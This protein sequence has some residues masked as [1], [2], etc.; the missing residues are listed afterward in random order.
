MSAML[1]KWSCAAFFVCVALFL[2]A[3][4]TV[5]ADDELER[6]KLSVLLLVDSAVKAIEGQPV[7]AQ[8]IYRAITGDKA[9][10]QERRNSYESSRLNAEETLIKDLKKKLNPIFNASGLL[11][12]D[13]SWCRK[14]EKQALLKAGPYIEENL[15]RNFGESFERARSNAVREQQESLAKVARPQ[16]RQDYEKIEKRSPGLRDDLLR[17]STQTYSEPIFSENLDYLGGKIDE[18]IREARQQYNRQRTIVRDSQGGGK[19]AITLHSIQTA[20]LKELENYR[21]S[22]QHPYDIFPSV[23]KSILPRAKEIALKK[24]EI[25]AESVDI[26]IPDKK[27]RD[28]IQKNIP[29]HRI[30]SE[31]RQLVMRTFLPEIQKKTME[32][33]TK[34]LPMAEKKGLQQFLKAQP[35]YSI[36]VEKVTENS[37]MR[38]SAVRGA[39]GEEQFAHTFPDLAVGSWKLGKDAVQ[40]RYNRDKR[41]DNQRI[42]AALLSNKSLLEETETMVAE[43]VKRLA[44]KGDLALKQ[45]MLLVDGYR[46]KTEKE[47][48]ILFQQ[49]SDD[50]LG[51]NAAI[52]RL[53][54]IASKEIGQTWSDMA[55]SKVY[56][57][58][59]DPVEDQ[60]RKEVKDLL[61][62][63]MKRREAL[64]RSGTKK[65]LDQPET[66]AAGNKQSLRSGLK[67]TSRKGEKRFGESGT[68]SEKEGTG[69]TIGTGAGGKGPLRSG[70]KGITSLTVF[71]DIDIES[72]KIV[73][74]TVR[75]DETDSFIFTFPL[76]R[77]NNKR[78][79]ALVSHQLETFEHR[80]KEVFSAIPE[81]STIRFVYCVTRMFHVRVPYGLVYDLRKRFSKA[82][83][84]G[85]SKRFSLF[86]YDGF[87]SKKGQMDLTTIKKKSWRLFPATF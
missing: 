64:R 38:F 3:Y 45:Q 30:R 5:G 52:D 57:A 49:V 2:D 46:K 55:L 4:S 12:I 48:Q 80:I 19:E 42:V 34:A 18:I 74:T 84:T 78:F 75:I 40:R 41:K 1:K 71:I 47:T 22:L 56:P 76:G 36:Q 39:I 79:Q 43:T 58:L 63:E 77:E 44:D 16:T 32:D 25:W 24:F 61:P 13:P 26:T 15:T 85:S 11:Q 70:K 33:Y 53:V 37:I 20:I 31:S 8:S 59:F 67:E 50:E 68:V 83:N 62:I 27:I 29:R 21:S 65:V 60:I 73:I 28:T 35:S 82:L 10:H 86:W 54:A 69:K 66:G 87:F 6:K 51:T 7:E 23:K 81:D 72:E 17:R 9:H 14:I